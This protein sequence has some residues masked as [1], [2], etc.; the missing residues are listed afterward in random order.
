MAKRRSSVKFAVTASIVIILEF[1]ICTGIFGS[2]QSN[3][4]YGMDSQISPL[5]LE[6]VSVENREELKA[7]Y[8]VSEEDYLLEV[9]ATYQNVGAYA[10]TFGRWMEFICPDDAYAC[11][12]AYLSSDYELRYSEKYSQVI[13]AGQHGSFKWMVVVSGGNDEIIL[14]ETGQKLQGKRQEVKISIPERNSH[15]RTKAIR[16]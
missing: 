8:D 10:G 15:K 16:G 1:V 3:L 2:A 9:T 13:P 14:R 12:E 5:V 7:L 6:E 11:Y 4:K